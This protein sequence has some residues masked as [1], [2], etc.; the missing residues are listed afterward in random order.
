VS[1]NF[2]QANRGSRAEFG[3]EALLAGVVG[4]EMVLL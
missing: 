4:V 3:F 1:T 2:L